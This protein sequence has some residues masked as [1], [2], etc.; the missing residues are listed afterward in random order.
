MVRDLPVTTRQ[1]GQHSKFCFENFK[2]H[3]CTES[4]C[5]QEGSGDKVVL[6]SQEEVAQAIASAV[7]GFIPAHKDFGQALLRQ[8]THSHPATP[9]QG[10]SASKLRRFSSLAAAARRPPHADGSVLH[11]HSH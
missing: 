10:D 1:F 4:R 8:M 11:P 2:Q 7:A 3:P 6:D 5:F 9:S